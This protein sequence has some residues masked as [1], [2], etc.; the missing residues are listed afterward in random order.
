MPA[1]VVRVVAPVRRP[2]LV[3]ARGCAAASKMIGDAGTIWPGA[4]TPTNVLRAA[5]K[6]ETAVQ[7]VRS[8]RRPAHI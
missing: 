1:N 2:L 5:V 3:V 6:R 7:V 8:D 4:R